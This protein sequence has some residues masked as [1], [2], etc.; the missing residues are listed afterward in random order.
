ML[1]HYKYGRRKELQVGE[2]LERYG[3]SWERSPRSRGPADLFAKRGSLCMLIQVKATRKRVTTYTRLSQ[4]EEDK[5]MTRAQKKGYVPVL[6]L[7]TGN[8]AWIIT[9]P[10]ERVIIKG[11]LK[12]LMHDY[13]DER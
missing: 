5:L 13:L 11:A 6:A 9:I 12:P 3:W 4:D 7:T 8:Y 10:D 1:T 2:M